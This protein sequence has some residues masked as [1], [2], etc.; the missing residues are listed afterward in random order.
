MRAGAAGRPIPDGRDW[1]RSR[2]RPVW[3]RRPPRAR[4]VCCRAAIGSVSWRSVADWRASRSSAG[5][6]GRLRC[7]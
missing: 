1:S 4:D 7:H 3:R 2:P 6:C 5:A